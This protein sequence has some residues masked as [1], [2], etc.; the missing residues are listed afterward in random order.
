MNLYFFIITNL[1]DFE[2]VLHMHFYEK[3]L[4]SFLWY[5]NFYRSLPQ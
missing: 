4:V 2:D 1:V 5:I 3:S